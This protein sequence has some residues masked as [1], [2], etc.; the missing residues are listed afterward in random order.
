ML[1][2]VIET[3]L[4]EAPLGYEVLPYLVGLVVTVWVLGWVLSLF[5]L[6]TRFRR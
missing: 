3:L 4:G 5:G 6:A 2:G 1:L